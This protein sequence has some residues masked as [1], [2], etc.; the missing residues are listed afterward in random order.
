VICEESAVA[1][2]RALK[3]AER[4]RPDR[5]LPA[6]PSALSGRRREILDMVIEGRQ[7]KWIAW[8]L[9]ISI[10]TVKYHLKRLYADLG[11]GSRLELQRL[12]RS[13]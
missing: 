2:A 1:L 3:F 5:D 12:H 9:G 4:D 8:R 13:H 10:D 11:V 7:N 6:L